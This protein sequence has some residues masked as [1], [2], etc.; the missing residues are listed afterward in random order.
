MRALRDRVSRLH[1]R[2]PMAFLASKVTG[3]FRLFSCVR[4]H[5]RSPC[6]LA[7]HRVSPRAPPFVRD[8]VGRYGIGVLQRLARNAPLRGLIG[9]HFFCL[10]GALVHCDAALGV[11]LLL[12]PLPVFVGPAVGRAVRLPQPV[13]TLADLRFPVFVHVVLRVCH[14]DHRSGRDGAD[15]APSVD[16]IAP[17]AALARSPSA[18]MPTSRFCRSTTGTRRICASSI[19]FCTAEMSSSS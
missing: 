2:R 5:L 1:V 4:R 9:R 11:E 7:A 6:R 3:L 18:T 10:P 8:L 17:S 12:G 16:D 15:T 19:F 13:R 14:G